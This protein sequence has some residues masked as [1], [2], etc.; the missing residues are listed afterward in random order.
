MVDDSPAWSFTI[1]CI[2]DDA[3]CE[4]EAFNCLKDVSDKNPDIFIVDGSIDSNGDGIEYAL[5]LQE[6]GIPV[7]LLVS[8]DNIPKQIKFSIEKNCFS[9]E[10][11][12]KAV[13]KAIEQIQ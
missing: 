11:L 12:I 9:P 7:V 13:E 3:G 1:T 8:G 10:A 4:V 6:Q 2:L 5:Q